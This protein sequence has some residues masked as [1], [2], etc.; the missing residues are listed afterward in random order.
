MGKPIPI[1]RDIPK[2]MRTQG[3]ETSQYL[4]EEKIRK[5]DSLS[6]GERKGNSPN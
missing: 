4:E 1:R 3:I 5:D 6:S 2:G